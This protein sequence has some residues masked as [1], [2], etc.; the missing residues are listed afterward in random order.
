[1]GIVSFLAIPIAFGM[2]LVAPVFI[3]LF[4][5]EAFEGA[6]V[7]LQI[8]AFVIVAI[9]FNNLTGVQV[10]IGLGYDK[11]F[12]YSVLSGAIFNFVLNSILIPKMGASGAAFASVMAETLILFITVYFVYKKTKV[13][14][15]GGNDILKSLVGSLLLFPVAYLLGKCFQGWGYVLSFTIL[16]CCVY[17]VSQF[18]LKSYSM[19]LLI[20]ILWSKIKKVNI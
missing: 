14:M 11:L 12:L 6:V 16:G 5:G 19:E 17:F 4:L 10:L 13:K 2:A 7:P 18:L 8:M 20:N 15:S 3:P 9:G 1:M